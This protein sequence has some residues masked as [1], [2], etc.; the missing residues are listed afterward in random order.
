MKKVLVILI[1][2]SFYGC[3]SHTKA[4]RMKSTTHC[5]NFEHPHHHH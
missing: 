3:V 1:L 4:L 5:P 2:S